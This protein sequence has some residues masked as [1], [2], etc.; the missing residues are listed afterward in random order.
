MQRAFVASADLKPMAMQLLENRSPAAYAGV[1]AYARKH[2]GSDP[3]ALANLVLGYARLLDRDYG[4][5][6]AP[7]KKAQAGGSELAD[8]ATF[9][10]GSA[11]NGS[12]EAKNA[13]ATL[14]EFERKYPGSVFLRDATV[15]YAN[16]LTAAGD[17]QQAASLLQRKRTPTRAD[18]EL[19]LG[20]AL[21]QSGEAGKA[22]EVLRNLYFTMPVAPEAEQAGSLVKSAAATGLPPVTLAQRKTRADLLSQGRRYRD[23]AREYRDLV[24]DAP[25]EQRAGLQVALGGALHRAGD[26][27]QA[28]SILEG[29]SNSKGELEAERLF[30]LVE[31]ARSDG[32]DERLRNV[33]SALREAG[34]GSSW[35]EQGLLQAGNMYL[36]QPDFDRAIESYRELQQRFPKGKLA[37]YAHWKVAWLN[38]RQGRLEDARRGFEQQL[39][40]YPASPQV[41][42]ALYWRARI[43]EEQGEAGRARQYYQKLVARFPN[44][45]YAD[46]A[47]E[48][49][50]EVRASAPAASE[51]LLDKIPPLTAVSAEEAEPPE[52]N[53]RWQKARLLE[54]GG[55]LE[56]AVRELQTAA[57][58]GGSVWATSAMARVYRQNGRHDRALQ[59]LKRIIPSY[60]AMDLQA[61]PREQWESLFPRAY[62][63][64]LRR[65]SAAN[66]LDPYVVA[67]LIRQESEFNPAA[68]SRAN[69]IGLMQL[70]PV[71]GRKL[72]R[73]MRIRRYSSEQLL[74]PTVNLQL[75][76]RYFRQLVDKYDGRLEY[77]LAAYNAGPDRVEA[78]LG[79]GK[80]RDPQEFVES[81]PFTETREYVQAVLRNASVYRKLYGTP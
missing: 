50:R 47:R 75:G 36:L 27:R 52:D 40:L 31:I 76:T 54:N 12:G 57:E 3:G 26:D 30:Y 13:V 37:A 34:A 33:L 61:L 24:P 73:E 17:P 81:I 7:L 66:Q 78:W 56:L 29:S 80:Y 44:F 72:A 62:W 28:R 19:A 23:A 16:A 67:S 10:L 55:L 59:L 70:L 25:S 14:Q 79:L 9:F 58:E 63:S 20:K 39:A 46:Q 42:A 5:A 77:A 51:P 53:V 11:Y 65:F 15:A 35:L 71:T 41:P 2:A 21:L 43:A 6:I 38:L 8:Y 48:R 32:D 64:D 22:I 60:F 1:E 18:L 49:L 4:K 74:K 69:A 68:V 45:Y